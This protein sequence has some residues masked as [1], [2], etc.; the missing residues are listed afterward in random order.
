MKIKK[1]DKGKCSECDNHAT[2]EL[3]NVLYCSQCADS[4]LIQQIG[5]CIKAVE[6]AKITIKVIPKKAL[7]ASRG[8]KKR[9]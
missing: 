1:V 9:I 6:H 3:D 5:K 7:E 8:D 4:L 2:R